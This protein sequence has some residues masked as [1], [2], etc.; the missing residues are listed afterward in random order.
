MNGDSETG[1]TVM[2]MDEGLD[3][4]DIIA[5]EKFPIG[6]RDNLETV[7]DTSAQIGA[8]LII[9]TLDKIED[10]TA[11]RTKQNEEESSYAPKIEKADQKIDFSFDAKTVSARIRGVTPPGAFAYHHGK[12]LKLTDVLATDGVG[13]PGEVISVESKGEGYIDVAC[14][15]GAVRV[16]TLVPEGK[17]KMSAGD[18]VRGR[19]I[20]K[21]DIL[22]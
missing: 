15:S 13:T 12:M 2:Q 20:Q 11:T 22:S 6:E 17:G 1:V 4:G 19:K 5:I 18:F 16:Y 3:T 8:R 10:G 14:K 9:S 21:G 7:H